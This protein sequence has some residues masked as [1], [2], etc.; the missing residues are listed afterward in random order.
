MSLKTRFQTQKYY[1]DVSY[2]ST[3]NSEVRNSKRL[4]NYN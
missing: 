4:R 3:P 2:V 1:F